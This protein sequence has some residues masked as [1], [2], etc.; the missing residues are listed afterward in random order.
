MDFQSLRVYAYPDSIVTL[1]LIVT[2]TVSYGN[3]LDFVKHAK[4]ILFYVRP[5]EYGE[6]YAE[7]L[8]CT[9]C[10]IGTFN[11]SPQRSVGI[12]GLCPDNALCFGKDKVAPQNGY[13]RLHEFYDVFV[14][15]MH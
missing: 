4:S 11:L 14:Q 15:C 7:D 5:C 13:Y 2:G 6:F 1:T 10:D 9:E 12:C 3:T 8:T